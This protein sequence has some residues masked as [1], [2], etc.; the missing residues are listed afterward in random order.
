M[1]QSPHIMWIAVDSYVYNEKLPHNLAD[2]LIFTH[3]IRRN[4]ADSHYLQDKLPRIPAD[5]QFWDPHQLRI[6][7]RHSASCGFHWG[8]SRI[9]KF[10]ITTLPRIPGQASG[11]MRPCRTA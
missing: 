5:S 6:P 8:L 1:F 11:P 4:G 7:R 2:L 9:T 3:R 10:T